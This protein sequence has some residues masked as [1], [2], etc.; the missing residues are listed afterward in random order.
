MNQTSSQLSNFI[1]M[2]W[3]SEN[4]YQL[5]VRKI[6]CFEF[7]SFLASRF[8]RRSKSLLISL[9]LTPNLLLSLLQQGLSLRSLA[10]AQVSP[11][12]Q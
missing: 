4:N 8:S 6:S 10:E 11:S 1:S 5:L 12:E 3:F 9:N 7:F 2:V